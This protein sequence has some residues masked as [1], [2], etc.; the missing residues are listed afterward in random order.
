MM[1]ANFKGGS[2]MTKG[3][4]DARLDSKY[5]DPDELEHMMSTPILQPMK[6][7]IAIITYRSERGPVCKTIHF[8]EIRE[9]HSEIEHGPSWYTIIDIHILKTESTDLT[10]EASLKQ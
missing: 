4:T 5:H 3:S 6:R 9:L 10:I 7:W 2:N 1:E 8:D